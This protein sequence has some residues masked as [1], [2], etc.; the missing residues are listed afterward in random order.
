MQQVAKEYDSQGNA[1]SRLCMLNLIPGGPQLLS[2]AP[3]NTDLRWCCC[4]CDHT[5]EAP[6]HAMSATILHGPSRF[7]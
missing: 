1:A 5:L 4:W 3:T 7:K 2:M 6:G